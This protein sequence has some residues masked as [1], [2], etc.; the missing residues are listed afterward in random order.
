MGDKGLH[1][2]FWSGSSDPRKL[3]TVCINDFSMKYTTAT[4]ALT[5][6]IL[7]ILI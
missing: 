2:I 1:S 6:G 4:W 5:G 3:I 7:K